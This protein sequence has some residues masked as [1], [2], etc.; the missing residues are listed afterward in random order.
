MA[1][2]RGAARF[3]GSSAWSELR[4]RATSRACDSLVN[5][6]TGPARANE[7]PVNFEPGPLLRG[8]TSPIVEMERA[9]A[10]VAPPCGCRGMFAPGAWPASDG[11]VNSASR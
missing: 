5:D 10:T 4:S 2:T 8:P 9:P 3:L 6:A 7:R 1:T 11:P